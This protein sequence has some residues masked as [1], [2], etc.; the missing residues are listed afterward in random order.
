M[1]FLKKIGLS[2]AI[3]A[4]LMAFSAPSFSAEALDID[5][6]GVAANIQ[7][8]ER[9]TQKLVAPPFLPEHNQVAKGGPK[10]LK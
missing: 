3:A 5:K 1:N 9:V 7:G 8:L 10:F 4:S 6:V 2:V